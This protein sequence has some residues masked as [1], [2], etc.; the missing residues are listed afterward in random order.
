MISQEKLRVNLTDCISPSF[1][2]LHWDVVE[3]RHTRYKL[4]GGRGSTKSSFISLEIILGMMADARQGVLSN[5]VVF[6]R[7]FNDIEGS[8]FG[9]LL[10]AI[11]KLEVSHLWKVTSSPHRLTYTPTGQAILFRG[12][13]KATKSKSIKVRKGYIKYLWFEELDEFEGP[14]KLRTIQQSIVRGG[15]AFC[16][17]YS[18]NPPRSQR[19][20]VN[21]PVQWDRPDTIQH[22]SDYRSVPREWL[23]EQFITDA[24]HLRKTSPEKYE[25]EYLG[26]IIGT[27]AEI[28][29]NLT[30]REIT[31]A[32]LKNF[33]RIRRGLDWGY[34]SDPF[35]YAVM[36]Y[37][38]TRRRLYIFHEIQLVNLSN[39]KAAAMIQAENT[40]NAEIVADSAEPKSI[41][42]MRD[43]GL[44]VRGARKGPD[45]VDFG[46]KWLS[47]EIEEIIIDP[48]RCPNTW[49]EFYG[50]ELERDA[51]G[52]LKAEYPDKDNHSIDAVRYGL[53]DDM[54]QAR[55][56]VIKT[57]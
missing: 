55:P 29:R 56:G 13:D 24:E 49:R 28:F 23:G 26:A 4:D 2:A 22:H 54:R 41:S 36:H 42:E 51:N 12:A 53:E 50:Y 39:R 37:D 52:N 8:V 14:E 19:S 48:V 9:Q 40:N 31:S 34:A 43:Y 38:R 21:D 7:Y 15:A 1:Y 11:D 27:G 16:V 6:R 20:W 5:T 47:E 44:R 3:G 25:H 45:S 17:F 35:H 46:V 30:N 10:W 33:D 32:E 57:R 18:Y